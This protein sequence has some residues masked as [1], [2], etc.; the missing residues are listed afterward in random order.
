MSQGFKTFFGF[1]FSK[2][3]F[4]DSNIDSISGSLKKIYKK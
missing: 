1:G 4:N 2:I 3:I